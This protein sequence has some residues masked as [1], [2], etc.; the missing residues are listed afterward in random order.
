MNDNDLQNAARFHVEGRPAYDI[1]FPIGAP[2]RAID[3]QIFALDLLGLPPTCTFTR[4]GDVDPPSV[5]LEA[6][7]VGKFPL[8]TSE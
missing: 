8:A 4:T 1:T 2:S 5:A 6:A 3:R 7:G